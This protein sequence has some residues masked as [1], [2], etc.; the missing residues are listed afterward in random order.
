MNFHE[1]TIVIF[2][3]NIS[4]NLVSHKLVILIP[5]RLKVTSNS[6]SFLASHHIIQNRQNIWEMFSM[7][8]IPVFSMFG[9]LKLAADREKSIKSVTFGV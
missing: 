4:M 9:H 1:K 2:E 5:L 8:E 7:F 6:A 3:S